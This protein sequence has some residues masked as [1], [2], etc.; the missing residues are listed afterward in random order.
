[1]SAEEAFKICA[2]ICGIA[3]LIM[4]FIGRSQLHQQ[5][6][7]DK[8][9]FVSSILTSGFLAAVILFASIIVKQ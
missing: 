8:A 3:A 1:M 6:P 4:A 5:S 7:A 2:A 9:A